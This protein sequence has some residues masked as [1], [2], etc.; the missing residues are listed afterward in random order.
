MQDTLESEKIGERKKETDFTL[1]CRELQPK[2]S[3]SLKR[4]MF[5][6]GILRPCDIGR[7][8]PFV[9]RILPSP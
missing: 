2:W 7:Q 3:Y 4:E 8:V 9:L 6:Q 5:F 1:K